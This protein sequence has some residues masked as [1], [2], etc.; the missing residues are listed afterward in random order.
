MR[1][2]FLLSYPNNNTPIKPKAKRLHITPKGIRQ[3]VIP[4]MEMEYVEYQEL[5]D[6]DEYDDEDYDDE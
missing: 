5:C 4:K 2:K 3:K 1:R 6:D